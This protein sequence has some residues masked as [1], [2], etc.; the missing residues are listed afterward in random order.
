MIKAGK[1]PSSTYA[2]SKRVDADALHGQ[3]RRES[4]GFV[5]DGNLPAFP[6][7]RRV[8]LGHAARRG[9]NTP[10]DGEDGLDN[11]GKATGSLAML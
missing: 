11:G 4:C 6:V 8:G 10:F 7:H 9:D 5:V 3:M 2:V 1:R